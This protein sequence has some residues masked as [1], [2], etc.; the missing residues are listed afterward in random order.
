MR[1]AVGGAGLFYLII[2]IIVT[3]IVFIG[4]I[5]RYASAYR[6]ANYVVTQIESCQGHVDGSCESYNEDE[7]VKKLRSSYGYSG[8][9]EKICIPN[10]SNA[11]VY[12]VILH[13]EFELP[14]IG[15]F[16]PFSVKAETKSLLTSCS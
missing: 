4:F 3:F 1:E 13:V 14:L 15:K 7:I 2:P 16:N 9:M 11:S 10:G 12:R 5:M 8:A 6:A